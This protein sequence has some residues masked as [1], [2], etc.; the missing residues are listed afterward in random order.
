[1]KASLKHIKTFF[2]SD[3]QSGRF[4]RGLFGN[5]LPYKDGYIGAC[6]SGNAGLDDSIDVIKLDKEYELVSQSTV[7]GGEDPRCFTYR[8]TPYALTWKP[9]AHPEGGHHFS[10]KVINLET[11]DWIVLSVEDVPSTPVAR[12]GKN[13]I[14][15]VKDDDLYFIL[16]IDPELSVLKCDIDTGVCSWDTEHQSELSIT[17]SRGGT[18]MVYFKEADKFIGLGHRTHSCH[19]HK[20][21]LYTL[22]KDGSV[23]IGPDCE[24]DKEGV[25][26]PLSLFWQDKKLYCCVGYFPVQ[27]G[28]TNV[29]WTDLYE[30]ILDN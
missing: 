11:K 16:S 3:K 12:L 19:N 10:Y 18:S 15:L 7:T 8:G 1:M 20:P 14:P 9:Y 2:R 4:D 28:E 25:H 23:F 5:V 29:A 26:D 27:A 30:V 17:I 24:V 13:W 6:R 22:S 21:F